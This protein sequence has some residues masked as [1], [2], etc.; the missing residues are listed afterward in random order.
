MNKIRILCILCVV[1]LLLSPGLF[2]KVSA[3]EDQQSIEFD[4]NSGH[5]GGMVVGVPY[6]DISTKSDAGFINYFVGSPL[7]MISTLD[8][9]FSRDVGDIYGS[10][11]ADDLF[12]AALAIGDFNGDWYY[13]LAVGVPGEPPSTN[14]GGVAVL[15]GVRGGLSST[16]SQWFEQGGA[17]DGLIG[18]GAAGDRLGAA[19][20]AGDINEDGYDDLVIGVPYKEIGTT[21]D[22]GGMIVVYG[23]SNGLTLSGNQWFDQDSPGVPEDAESADYFGSAFAMADINGDGFSDLA[24]GVPGESVIYMEDPLF[25]AG[26]VCI[27]Y[28]TSSG[29]TATDSQWFDQNSSD[30]EEIPGAYERMGFTLAAGDID[31]DGYADLAIGVPG[32]FVGTIDS[33]G[34]FHILFGSASGLTTDVNQWFDRTILESGPSEYDEFGSALT[35]NYFNQD[36]YADLVVGI[37]GSDSTPYSNVGDTYHFNG[38]SH[39]LA[40][41]GIEWYYQCGHNEVESNDRFGSSLAS[42]DLNYDGYI[43]LAVGIPGESIGDPVESAAG[44]VQILYNSRDGLSCDHYWRIDQT[45]Y[46]VQGVAEAGDRFGYSIAIW[47]PVYEVYLPMITRN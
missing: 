6:E 21:T 28:G 9:Y 39:G 10:S 26:G 18:T 32:E 12:A 16:G 42:G 1:G 35:I 4:P 19:L 22:S 8:M 3:L 17:A 33:A 13:D 37:P 45:P 34:G 11:T 7:E 30:I 43:D 24:V 5:Y 2:S 36:G 27:F 46:E 41:T 29:L 20:A 40:A 44:A 23:S 14:P 15:Y 25:E 31:G 47:P 38:T